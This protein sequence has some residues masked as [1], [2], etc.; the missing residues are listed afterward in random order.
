ML[1]GLPVGLFRAVEARRDDGSAATSKASTAATTAVST[2]E[3]NALTLELATLDAERLKLEEE[4]KALDGKIAAAK[5]AQG[6]PAPVAAK[7]FKNPWSPMAKKL[8]LLK[9]KLDDMD[10]ENSEDYRDLMLQFMEIA[11]ELMEESGFNLNEF[12]MSPYGSPMLMLAVLEGA[13]PPLDPEAML[14]AQAEVAKSEE[15]WKAL[16]AK[17]DDLTA[18]EWRRDGAGLVWDAMAGIRAQ[19]TP[20]QLDW[21]KTGRMWS[22]QAARVD[23]WNVA[24]KRDQVESQI[25]GELSNTLNLKDGAEAPLRPLVSE[26]LRQY[27]TMEADWKA[28]AAADRHP[29]D[30]R[31]RRPCDRGPEADQGFCEPDRGAIEGAQVVRARVGSHAYGVE[32]GSPWGPGPVGG[33]Q[34]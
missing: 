10:K 22:D 32:R 21:F 1:K 17:K 3:S 20:D 2:P 4:L 27:G 8:F 31:P 26:F 12:E 11:K 29:E 19:L 23:S 34:G 13:E 5:K 18:L 24:G 6:G 25:L 30:A 15:A 28:K 9:D 33:W 14:R 16:N 7:T